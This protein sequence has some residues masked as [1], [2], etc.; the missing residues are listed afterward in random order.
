[1][2]L[3]IKFTV[4]CGIFKM[5]KKKAQQFIIIHIHSIFTNNKLPRQYS[6]SI[7]KEKIPNKIGLNFKLNPSS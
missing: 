2:D 1:M 3:G 4:T 6:E 5:Y 7:H